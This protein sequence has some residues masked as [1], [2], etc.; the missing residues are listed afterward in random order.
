MNGVWNDVLATDAVNN[1]GRV[2][3]VLV[4]SWLCLGV[5]DFAE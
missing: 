2:G 1:S 5:D 4:V 3:E